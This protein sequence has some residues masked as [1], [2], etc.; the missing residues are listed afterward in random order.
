MQVQFAMQYLLHNFC[1]VNYAL[2]YIEIYK[3]VILSECHFKVSSV[4]C[5]DNLNSTLIL[6][7]STKWWQRGTE[8]LIMD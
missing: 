3:Q 5:L 7:G 4:V 1:R 2:K 8:T 6:E